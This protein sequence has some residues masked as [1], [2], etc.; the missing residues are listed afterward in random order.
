[1]KLLEILNDPPKNRKLQVELAMTTDA[2]EQFVKATWLHIEWKGMVYL[3]LQ[4]RVYILVE[5]IADGSQQ[6]EVFP[7]M[8]ILDLRLQIDSR[9]LLIVAIQGQCD[10]PVAYSVVT[11]SAIV[12]CC[13]CTAL[14]AN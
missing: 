7:K 3:Y 2:G 12:F 13:C 9:C 1:M 6:M 11:I 10:V 14:I 8:F 5:E 4:P